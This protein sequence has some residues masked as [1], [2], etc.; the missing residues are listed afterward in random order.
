MWL[1]FMPIWPHAGNAHLVD[2]ETGHT[3]MLWHC[4]TGTHKPS[5]AT[6]PLRLGI[7]LEVVTTGY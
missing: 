7:P 1:G 3:N 4:G 2:N 5:L 6:A